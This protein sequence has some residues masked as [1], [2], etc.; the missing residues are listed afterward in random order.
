MLNA[1][2]PS[3]SSVSHFCP[4]LGITTYGNL[5]DVF[6]PSNPGAN[7]VLQTTTNLTTRN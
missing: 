3:R 2:E 1:R 6:F 7:F 5:P 4:S